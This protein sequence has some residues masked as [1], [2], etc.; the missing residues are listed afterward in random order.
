M[1]EHVQFGGISGRVVVSSSPSQTMAA[2]KP[3]VS[4]ISEKN[5]STIIYSLQIVNC[6]FDIHNRYKTMLIIYLMVC[7]LEWCHESL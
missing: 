2:F 7:I 6:S 1:H 3:I 4:L 5:Y